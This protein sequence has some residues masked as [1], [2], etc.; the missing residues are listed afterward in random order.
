[1]LGS[2]YFV[3]RTVVLR[4][5]PRG[6]LRS[7]RPIALGVVLDPC[8]QATMAVNGGPGGRLRLADLQIVDSRLDD[9]LDIVSGIVAGS[10]TAV[11]LSPRVGGA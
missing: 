10:L 11:F 8:L 2:S 7:L 1:M 6:D 4:H 9:F 5:L 3:L